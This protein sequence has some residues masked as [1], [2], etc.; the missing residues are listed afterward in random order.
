MIEYVV[1]QEIKN[2]KALDEDNLRE[3]L[4]LLS[5]SALVTLVYELESKEL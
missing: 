4:A 5:A 1:E 3:D 2:D